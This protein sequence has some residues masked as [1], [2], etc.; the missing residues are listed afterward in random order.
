MNSIRAKIRVRTDRRRASWP[1]DWVIADL[2][3]V[4]RGWGTYFRHGNSAAKFAAIDAY[5]LERLARLDNAKH[6][7]RGIGWTNHHRWAWFTS[8]P[9][10]RLSGTVRYRPTHALR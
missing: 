6:G 4:L 10:H 3:P 9:V 8:L 7:R 5:V 1:L 2:N